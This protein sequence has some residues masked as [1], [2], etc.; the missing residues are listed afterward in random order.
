MSIAL[1]APGPW[2]RTGRHVAS[3]IPVAVSLSLCVCVCVPYRLSDQRLLVLTHAEWRRIHSVGVLQAPR[4][5]K[6]PQMVRRVRFLGVTSEVL[7][8]GLSEMLHRGG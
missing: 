8:P 7:A 6:K 4:R 3:S 2:H 5:T 1:A